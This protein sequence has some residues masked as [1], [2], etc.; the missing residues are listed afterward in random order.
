MK[1]ADYKTGY[2]AIAGKP[3]VGKSTILN[4]L[5]GVELAIVSSKPETTRNK[6]LGTLTT[7]EGQVIFLDTPGMHIPHTLLGR[8]MVRQAKDALDEA[9]LILAIIDAKKQIDKNDLALFSAIELAGKPAILLINK[10]DLIDKRLILPVID[11][12]HKLEIFKD[13]LPVSAKTGDNM[14]LILPRLLQLLPKSEKY[15]PDDHLT[16]RPQRFFIS[17][18]IRQ[19]VLNLTQQEVPHAVAVLVEEV[20]QRPGKLVFIQ[21][22]IYVERPTQKAIIIGKRGQMLKNIGQ[23]ARQSIEEFINNRVYLEL[24]VKVYKNWRKDPNALKMLGL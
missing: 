7:K 18:L 10:M 13:F 15:F 6:I 23:K 3:N 22:T 17:E 4:Y 16:D 14:Q 11:R 1:P 9:D 8:Y 20:K 5:I 19:Q 12:C 21:A 2:V 24:W